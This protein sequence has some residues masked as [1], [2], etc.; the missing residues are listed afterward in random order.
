MPLCDKVEANFLEKNI[1]ASEALKQYHERARNRAPVL[2]SFSASTHMESPSVLSPKLSCQQVEWDFGAN[3]NV[4]ETRE[5]ILL[6]E[7]CSHVCGAF[8][9][10]AETCCGSFLPRGG[11]TLALTALWR[12][13]VSELFKAPTHGLFSSHQEN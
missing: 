5:L 2:G 8:F 4:C 9:E 7:E 3:E 11:M 13:N 6:S 10:E 12:V 1:T